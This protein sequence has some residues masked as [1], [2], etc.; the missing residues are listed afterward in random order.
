MNQ[1]TS[2]T[3]IIQFFQISCI[4]QTIFAYPINGL[5]FYYLL[6]HPDDILDDNHGVVPIQLPFVHLAV[7]QEEEYALR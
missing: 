4:K 1:F 6:Q 2:P 3:W 5:F 7:S